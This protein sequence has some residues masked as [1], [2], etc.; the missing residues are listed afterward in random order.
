MTLWRDHV[1][2]P[3]ELGARDNLYEV[4]VRALAAAVAGEGEVI[5]TGDDGVRSLA[6]SLAVLESLR[7]GSAPRWPDGPPRRVHSAAD[8]HAAQVVAGTG[9]DRRGHVEVG[10]RVHVLLDDDEEI[11][12]ER[13]QRLDH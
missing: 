4:T 13:G 7:T 10:Q 9:G 6:V 8:P 12:V 1:A 5:V 3:V 11:S 2:E